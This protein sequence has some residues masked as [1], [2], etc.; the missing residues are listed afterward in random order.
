MVLN[1][2]KD[3]LSPA[4]IFTLLQMG[5]RVFIRSF[6]YFLNKY[7]MPQVCF[8]NDKFV[9]QGG[10]KYYAKNWPVKI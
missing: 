7:K 8:Q 9:N 10:K 1:I 3:I 2:K 6:L 5:D 4:L